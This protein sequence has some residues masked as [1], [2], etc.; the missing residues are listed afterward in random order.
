MTPTTATAPA[1]TTIERVLDLQSPPDRVWAAL[2]DPAEISGWFG[3]VT[4]F[5]PTVGAEGW[6]DFGPDGRIACRVEAVEVGRYLAWRW[7]EEPGVP[8]DES[9]G[10]LVEWWLEPRPNGGTRLRMLESGLHGTQILD[11]NTHGWFEEL[12][13]LREHL[14]AEPWQVPIRRTIGVPADRDKV[15]RAFADPDQFHAWWGFSAPVELR[16]GWEGWFD[17]PVHGRHAFRI[18]AAEAP[19][20]LA[21][22]W[23]ADQADVPLGEA[24][25]PTLVEWSLVAREDGGTDV[26]VAETGFTDPKLHAENT[27]GWAE[28]LPALAKAVE[29]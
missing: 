13:E 6:F 28:M 14:A 12:A 26:H 7:A 9:P 17:F 24:A 23:A 11:L 29:G 16:A 2:T 8:V 18:E 20:Y 5:E 27:G 1:G 4:S 25:Q 21:W 10:G 15:W 22:T 3:S 19:R